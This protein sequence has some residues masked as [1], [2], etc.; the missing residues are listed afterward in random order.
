MEVAQVQGMG[1]CSKK[2][3]KLVPRNYDAGPRGGREMT[4][5]PRRQI[6]KCGAEGGLRINDGSFGPCESNVL[7]R[8]EYEHST[9][10]LSV[11]SRESADMMYLSLGY[12]PDF[13]F[14]WRFTSLTA[15]Q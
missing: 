6:E 1:L 5:R 15:R 9:L 14:P 12:R 2:V 7:F 8:C 4:V 11:K 10:S 13:G 3:G